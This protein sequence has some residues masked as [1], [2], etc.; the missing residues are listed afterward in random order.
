MKQKILF[1]FL[2]NI[3]LITN[4]ISFAGN[5]ALEEIEYLD[6]I[7]HWAKD[8]IVE[9]TQNQIVNGYP[10]DTFKPNNNVTVAEF[11]KMIVS[12]CG[13]KIQRVGNK[14]WPD[15]YINTALNEKL[16]L[17][18]EFSNYN[19]PIN[20]YDAIT[21]ISRAVDLSD[22]K[23]S[24]NIFTDLRDEYE[25]NV[26]KLVKLKV[27]NGYTDKTIK[28]ENT[29]TRAEAVTI[30]K[31]M[32]DA[33]KDMILEKYYDLP[34]RTDLS[35][36]HSSNNVEPS[37]EIID[38]KL[39]IYDNG[40]YAVLDGYEVNCCKIDTSK[41]NEV[42][43][44]IVTEGSYT[45][46]IYVP[47]EYTINQ[48]KIICAESEDKTEN[49]GFD[50]AFT[51][52]QDKEYELKRISMEDKF[53]EKC[54]MKIEALKLWSNYSEYLKG[55]YIDEIKEEKLYQALKA[56]FGGTDGNKILKYII[57]KNKQYVSNKSKDRDWV[58][59]KKVGN[60]TINFYQPIGSTPKFY[61]SMNK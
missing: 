23:K 50:F 27:I 8:N 54:F 53:S 39:L 1:L 52:Y 37:Y 48:L 30:L 5:A 36:Y 35:N 14:V 28:G 12:A 42:I 4:S 31:R 60:Y 49:S 2:I 58:E 10:D 17:E 44:E 33:K 43:K 56:I 20:R 32:L 34:S 25:D 9:F 22:I 24:K 16:I 15:F 3:I 26:L 6:I 55:N 21:I 18:N 45:K 51:F 7:N 11:L 59:V 38:N 19:A 57:D 61:I 46:V 40:R 41:I 29:I 13:Y 47:S